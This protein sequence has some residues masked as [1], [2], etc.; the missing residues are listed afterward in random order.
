MFKTR[1][2][3]LRWVLVVV[4]ALVAALGA[5]GSANAVEFVKD[6]KIG[7]DEVINDDVFIAGEN[8]VMD[9]TV[10]GDLFAVGG[11][12]TING[13]VGGSLAVFAQTITVNGQVMGS[14]YSGGSSVVLG[15]S[16]R[17]GRNV[18]F[19]GFSLKVERGSLVGRDVLVGGYQALI[20]GD[21]GR[22]VSAGVGALE[23][24]GR[25]RGD[26]KTEVG[27]SGEA[28]PMPSF[29]GPPGAPPMV[30]P[31][32]RIAEEAYIG[33][34]LIYTSPDK[35]DA[36]VESAPEGGIVYQTPAPRTDQRPTRGANIAAMVGR[37]LI[38][39]MREL[40]TLLILGALALWKLPDLFTQAVDKVREEPLPAAGWG[41]LAWIAGYVAAGVI[42]VVIITIGIILSLITFGGLAFAVFG[43]GFAVLGLAFTLFLLLVTYGSKLVVAL[44]VGKWLVKAVSPQSAEQVA[45]PMVVGVLLYVILHAIPFVGWLA[46]VI[47][48]LVG[49]GG[50]CLVYRDWR[51]ER[52]AEPIQD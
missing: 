20:A 11:N 40:I 31:G 48:T 45:W 3:G 37:W 23:L 12:V 1:K 47:A 49:L 46:A 32:L 34:K 43:V 44:L 4:L 29:Y 13:T 39:R 22:N 5:V 6:G 30:A 26:V 38:K 28:A 52:A 14:M 19:G 7:R 24:S 42:T 36:I 50:M 8:V 35:G 15:S 25:V 21:V 33:G 10:N 41:L 51:A 18:Y 17:V 16:G 27:A 2:R 9:G